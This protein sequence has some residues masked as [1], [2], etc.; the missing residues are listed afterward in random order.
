MRA[1]LVGAEYE[2]NLALRSLAAALREDG[3]QAVLVP[4]EGTEDV[5]TVAAACLRHAPDLV[6]LSLPFQ[7]RVAAF[8]ALVAA[9]RA[10][11]YRGH[12]CAGGH[13]PT[14]AWRELLAS[15]PGLDTVVRHDGEVTLVELCRALATPARWLSVAGVCARDAAGVPR[16]APPRRQIDDLDALPWPVRDG[17]PVRHVGLPFATISGSRGCYADCNFCCINSWHRG[18]VGRRYRRRSPGSVAAE[19]ARLYRDRGVRVFCFHDDTFLLPRPEDSRR[20][21]AA[22][23]E[24]LARRDVGL[25]AVVAKCRP[26]QL[27]RAL[28][29]EARALG[30]VR[31]YVG[32]ENG[33]PAGVQHL[34]RGHSVADSHRALELC[35][36]TGVF[37]C[38]NLLP[39]E[40]DATLE[41]VAESFDF[42]ARHIDVPFNF[43]RTEVYAGS[44]YERL[45]RAAGRLRGAFPSFGY[46][47]ADERAEMLFRILAVAFTVRNFASESLAN[48]SSA[49]GYEA[50]VLSH[51]HPSRA[52]TDLR[53]RAAAL[54]VEVN[55]D[56]LAQLRTACAFVREGGWRDPAT[57]QDFA[58][59]LATR[60]NLSGHALSTR[61][62]RLREAIRLEAIGRRPRVPGAAAVTSD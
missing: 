41:D 22:L 57:A 5:R 18:A 9:L 4:F 38:Y 48:L 36:A 46:V 21:L 24:D 51:F 55:R 13:V 26:D 28:L 60:T 50:S 27:D 44:N 19:M 32:V 45:L 56:T 61:I 37:A 39:F 30:V 16:A 62:E 29:E 35:A 3:Q 58:V 52:A 40:P 31:F 2:E 8:L 6:G 33:S 53:A 7:H 42:A 23:R 43:G 1:V 54:T 47:I 59:D 11:G 20:R 15:A 12:V 14:A 49:T 25:V 17:P 10:L 34:N